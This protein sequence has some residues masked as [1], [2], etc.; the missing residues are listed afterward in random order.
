MQFVQEQTGMDGNK[1]INGGKR[2]IAVDRPG[3]PWSL[4][5]TWANTSDNQAGKVVI[6]RLRGKVPRLEMWRKP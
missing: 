4:A 2:T 6:D 3:L 1:K 5:V